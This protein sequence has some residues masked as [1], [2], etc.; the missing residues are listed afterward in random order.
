MWR[1]ATTEK[2]AAAKRSAMVLRRGLRDPASL[3]DK[4]EAESEAAA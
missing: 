4:V 2:S 1:G 3:A